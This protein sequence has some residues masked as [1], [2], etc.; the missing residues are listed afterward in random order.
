[1]I[2]SNTRDKEQIKA[3]WLLL[4]GL[5]TL[6]KGLDGPLRSC[7]WVIPQA[8]SGLTAL[9]KTLGLPTA[10]A[11]QPSPYTSGRSW[12][13]PGWDLT[14]DRYGI[15]ALYG[16][17]PEHLLPG[18][19]GRAGTR[20]P[21]WRSCSSY[22]SPPGSLPHALEMVLLM[23]GCGAGWTGPGWAPMTSWPPY[24]HST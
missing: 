11:P 23:S 15:L 1:M 13:V 6:G 5:W 7:A 3:T 18:A 14:Y 22:C 8:C 4:S 9:S 2:H 20:I 21:S 16:V 19:L 24:P 12:L 10:T 17:L